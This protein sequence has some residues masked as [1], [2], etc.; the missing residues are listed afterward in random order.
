MNN[1]PLKVMYYP[2]M[3]YGEAWELQKRLVKAIDGEQQ[4]EHLLLFPASADIYDRVPSATPSICC[5]VR[6]SLSSGDFR[7]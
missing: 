7:V 1:I 3:E 5:L 2:M 6:K 4:Q